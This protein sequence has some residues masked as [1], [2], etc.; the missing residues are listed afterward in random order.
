[1]PIVSLGYPTNYSHCDRFDPP[2]IHR[3]RM[4]GWPAFSG[5]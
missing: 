5:L 3:E 1:M 2:G 4:Q